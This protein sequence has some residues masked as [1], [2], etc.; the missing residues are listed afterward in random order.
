[1]SL[2]HY[3]PDCSCEKV[4]NNFS[5]GK[6]NIFLTFPNVL[7]ISW[8]PIAYQQDCLLCCHWAWKWEISHSRFQFTFCLKKSC[9]T[10]QKKVN[11]YQTKFDFQGHCYIFCKSWREK[12]FLSIFR[13]SVHFLYIYCWLPLIMIRANPIKN[14]TKTT[15]LVLN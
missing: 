14:V 5:K 10:M 3:Q 6:I 8:L 1:M 12:Y 4:K 9:F 7:Y 11:V 2:I 13:C 15:Q